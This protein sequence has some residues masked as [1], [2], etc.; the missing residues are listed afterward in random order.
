MTV[1]SVLIGASLAVAG[2]LFG[3]QGSAFA[4]GIDTVAHVRQ[5][6][7]AGAQALALRRVEALQPRNADVVSWFEWERLRLDLL[8][9]TGQDK[10]L[11]ERVRAYP[12]GLLRK[13]EAWPLL[14]SA[15]N[16]ALRSGDPLQARHWLRRWFANAQVDA[17]NFESVPYRRARRLVLD[18]LLLER[19]AESAYRSM[20]RFQQDFAPLSTDEAE[21][22]VAG[23]L[24]LNRNTEAAQWLA[25]L[26][27]Q[28]HYSALL[29][30][31]AGLMAPDVASV[32]ARSTLA[33]SNDPA[34]L[35][36]LDAAARMQNDRAVLVE[37]AELRLNMEWLSRGS[38]ARADNVESV[39]L[40]TAYEDAALHGANHAQLLVGDDNGWLGHA[41]RIRAK[42]P[43]MSR[44][45]LAYLLWKSPSDRV[46]VEAQRLLIAALKEVR[47]ERVAIMLFADP[48]RFPIEAMDPRV[49]HL[50]GEIHADLGR[51]E[52][53][54][55][56]WRGLDAPP[57]LT[58]EQWRLRR[59]A[60]Y[61]QTDQRSEVQ[62]VLSELLPEH[63][64]VPDEVR[65]GLLDVGRAALASAQLG[66]AEDV[67]KLLRARAV[68]TE[69]AAVSMALAQVYESTARPREAAD[70]Y[71]DAALIS[72]SPTTERE[73]LQARAAAARNLTRIGMRGDARRIY[74]WLLR[75]AKDPAARESAQRALM[76]LERA[77]SSSPGR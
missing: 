24:R 62:S 65:K 64:P 72:I 9:A 5:I 45:L 6:A 36:L 47:L 14:F 1:R 42:Q 60:M 51:P 34:A 49:R 68:D 40:W 10:P 74:E 46:R 11:V 25:Q 54:S 44:A 31:R 33:K 61:V 58:S 71:L 67:L 17:A 48:A 41:G 28:S 19:N 37:V 63:R 21:G 66:I 27:P 26:S 57:G 18:A 32:Q 56:Y 59:L 38:D 20:L 53:A 4:Q 13:R 15:A 22:F 43:T 69:R 50:L 73:S 39:A 35:A 3:V 16:A 29:R 52:Q 77:V 76:L 55:S 7:D 30:I 8:A 12:D 2:L 23:L 70:A 75:N